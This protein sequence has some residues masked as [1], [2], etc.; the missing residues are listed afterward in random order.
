MLFNF[1]VYSA[2]SV[3]CQYY[4]FVGGVIA[5]PLGIFALWQLKR[6]WILASL[7]VHAINLCAIFGFA[8]YINNFGVFFVTMEFLVIVLYCGTIYYTY[9][10]WLTCPANDLI[11]DQCVTRQSRNSKEYVIH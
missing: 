3:F 8:Y 11:L 5:F 6:F 1:L 7:I 10:I 4:G 9:E 2:I